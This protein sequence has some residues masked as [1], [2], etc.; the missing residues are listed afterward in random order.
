[1]KTIAWLVGIMALSTS[2]LAGTEIKVCFCKDIDI[3]FKHENAQ[4]RC[5]DTSKGLETFK[6]LYANGWR[7]VEATKSGETSLLYFERDSV[8]TTPSTGSKGESRP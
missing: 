1:M 7:L 2:V 6:E 4:L 8:E 5:S 3:V